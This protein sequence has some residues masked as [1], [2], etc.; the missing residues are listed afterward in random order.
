MTVT[1]GLTVYCHGL[2]GSAEE[3][4]AFHAQGRPRPPVVKPMDSDGFEALTSNIS[5]AE[6][7]LIGFSLGAMTALHLAALHPERVNTLT[8]IAPAA[9]LELGNFLPNMVGRPVFKMA[10]SGVIPFKIFT[11]VQRLGVSLAAT[12]IIQTMFE[13]SPEPDMKLLSNPIFHDALKSGLSQSLGPD[14]TAYRHAVHTYVKP[15]ADI[16]KDIKC[17]VTIHHGTLDNWAPIEMSYALQKRIPAQID[18]VIY[19]GLGHYSTL[20]KAYPL[21]D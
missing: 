15:W 14:N 2:P 10:K 1:K 3:I 11:A 12:K 21:I 7:H 4:E 8:L 16:L 5:A 20:H 19:E 9:P 6:V 13:G 18:L 17:P